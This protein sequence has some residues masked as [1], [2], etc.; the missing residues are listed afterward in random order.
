MRM[1]MLGRENFAALPHLQFISVTSG[2][3]MVFPVG[4][5]RG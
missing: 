4:E 3:G 5:D 1:V 2:P